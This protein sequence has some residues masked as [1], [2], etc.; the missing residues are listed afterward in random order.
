MMSKMLADPEMKKMMRDQQAQI[1]NQFYGPLIKEMGLTPEE[2]A[3]FKELLADSQMKGVESA[4]SLLGGD[5]T[6]RTETLNALTAQQKD[7]EDQ[8][9]ELLGDTRYAQYKDYEQTIGQRMQLDQFRQQTAGGAN[10]L[11]DQQADKLLAFMKEEKQNV[12]ALTGQPPPGT[13]QDQANWQAMLSGEQMDKLMQGQEDADQKV[14]ERAKAVLSSEQLDAFGAFQTNQLS[15]MR[16][17]M[18]MARKF[19]APEGGQA[20]PKQ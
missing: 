20:Q 12:A 13:G 14:Y 16:I 6:N 15:M 10:A 3:K 8:V 18:T 9:K 1:M 11:T 19:F 7:Q 5:S 4:G 2:A 17:G